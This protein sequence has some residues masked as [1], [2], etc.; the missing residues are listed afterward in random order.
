MNAPQKTDFA[1]FR[2]EIL[3]DM[4]GKE[5]K[6]NEKIADLYKCIERIN[7]S[8]DQKLDIINSKIRSIQE[9]M[10][11]EDKININNNIYCS[12][13]VPKRHLLIISFLTTL[14]IDVLLF[15]LFST[16]SK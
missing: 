5:N 12:N 6:I 8:N 15:M 9:Y 3:G 14:S 4:K 10:L 13:L 2:N 11:L 7:T 1:Y 16:K